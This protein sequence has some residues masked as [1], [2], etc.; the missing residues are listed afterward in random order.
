[1]TPV[2]PSSIGPQNALQ[3]QLGNEAP[4]EF[5]L[6]DD[7]EHERRRS[8]ERFSRSVAPVGRRN[9]ARRQRKAHRSRRS[10][11]I[12]DADSSSKVV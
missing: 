3:P 1:M 11:Q 5:E 2:T 7:N 6:S 8:C 12:D 9:V 10:Q 4:S